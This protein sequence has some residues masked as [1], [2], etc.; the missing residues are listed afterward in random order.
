M[1]RADLTLRP[2]V[3]F[4]YPRLLETPL[5]GEWPAGSGFFRV[6]ELP[7]YPFSGEGEHAALTVEKRDVSTRELALSVAKALGVPASAVGYAG[8]KDKDSVSVQCFTVMSVDDEGVAK[9]FEAL[10]AK[11][12]ARS[13]HKNKLRLGHLAGN[14]FVIG[15]R[16]GDEKT[17]DEV[18]RKLSEKGVPNYY[19]PQRFGSGGDN[20]AE[21]LRL[22]KSKKIGRLGRWKKD[23]LVSSLQSFIFNEVLAR[24]VERGTLFTALSG[25][26]LQKEDSGGIFICEDVEADQKRLDLFEISPTGPMPGKKMKAPVGEVAEAEAEVLAELGIAPELFS[27]E[28]GTRRELRAKVIYHGVE[29]TPVGVELS[30]S[31]PPGVFATSV[32]REIASSGAKRV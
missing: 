28:T 1:N 22:M 26:V 25:D 27:G 13:R 4:D 20:A 23:L 15:L 12:L 9:A 24:R 3:D 2:Y 17:A 11:V 10:G 32:V 7:L 19:G 8:M 31:C 14:K 30:F 5:A 29:K 6:E 21:A 16:G 18:L